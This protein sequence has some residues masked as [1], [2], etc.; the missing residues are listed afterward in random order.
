LA[1][2]YNRVKAVHLGWSGDIADEWTYRAKLSYNQTYGTVGAPI[3]DIMGN[4][5]TFAEVTYVPQTLNG[6][7]FCASTAFDTGDIYGDN[8]G[9]QL[10]INKKF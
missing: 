6:W 1:F 7:K 10:K 5:S 8:W 2:P 3:L 9:V 4:Y